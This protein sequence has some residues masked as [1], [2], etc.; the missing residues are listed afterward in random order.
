MHLSRCCLTF[1]AVVTDTPGGVSASVTCIRGVLRHQRLST[2]CHQ[3]VIEFGVKHDI[4]VDP[5]LSRH[6]RRVINRS[7]AKLQ[8]DMDQRAQLQ[9]LS[10]EYQNLQTGKAVLYRMIVA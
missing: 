3:Q 2:L 4:W 8:V 5:L 10:D 1:E 6:L 7:I 9:A